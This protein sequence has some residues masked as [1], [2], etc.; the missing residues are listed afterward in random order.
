M[1]GPSVLTCVA[2]P[3]GFGAQ[4]PHAGRVHHADGTVL[5][6]GALRQ[7][8]GR[9]VDE[10]DM[11]WQLLGRV[12]DVPASNTAAGLALLDNPMQQKT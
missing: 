9:V 3:N 11:T 1:A 6:L 10:S 2:H 8:I 12:A 5:D 4:G 7:R